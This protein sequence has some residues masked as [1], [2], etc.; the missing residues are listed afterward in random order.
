MSSYLRQF[1]QQYISNLRT[2][3]HIV[4][5]CVAFGGKLLVGV[6][7]GWSPVLVAVYLEYGVSAKI[8]TE[9]PSNVT[10]MATVL[11]WFGALSVAVT[12]SQVGADRVEER[13]DSNLTTDGY[14]SNIRQKSKLQTTV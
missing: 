13:H 1:I 7:L 4:G 2:V 9:N 11:W 10:M 8:F 6:A 12:A 3:A 14:T 5:I